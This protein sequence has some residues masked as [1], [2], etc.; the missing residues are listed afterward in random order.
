MERIMKSQALSDN[1]SMAYMVGKKNLELN[2]SHPIIIDL[3]DKLS[4]DE[5]K[6]VATDLVRLLY[7]TSLINSG[8]T[9]E[10]TSQFSNRIFSIIG[11][12]LGLDE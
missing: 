10:D 12:G 3:K 5:T 11:M 7:D 6:K 1:S 8:F 2:P 4:N 9:L